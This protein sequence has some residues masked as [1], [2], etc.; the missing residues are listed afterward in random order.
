VNVF[1]NEFQL[2]G[3]FFKRTDIELYQK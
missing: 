2:K 3:I 1:E